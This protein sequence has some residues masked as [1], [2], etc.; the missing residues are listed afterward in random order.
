[1]EGF[2][3]DFQKSNGKHQGVF[4]QRFSSPPRFLSHINLQQKLKSSRSG[5]SARLLGDI[6]LKKEMATK[7]M[8][9]LT[10]KLVSLDDGHPRWLYHIRKSLEAPTGFDPLHT[11]KVGHARLTDKRAIFQ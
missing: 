1:M 5:F 11:L 7:Q 8:C 4:A 9:C 3:D 10:M 6:G 2:E